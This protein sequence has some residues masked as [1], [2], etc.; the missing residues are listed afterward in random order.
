[1]AD[2][3]LAG[4]L[5]DRRFDFA[6]ELTEPS[7][8]EC[9]GGFK[10]TYDEGLEKLEARARLA[11]AALWAYVAVSAATA[12]GEL[13][14]AAGFLNIEVDMG[15]LAVAVGLTYLAYTAVMLLSVVLVA[16]WIHRAH[17]NLVEGGVDGL[18]FTPGWAVGWYFIPFANLVK[19]FQAMRELWTAS[20]GEHDPFGGQAPS[21]VKAWWA[22]WIV[23]NIL[24]TVS[25]RILLAS[26]GGPSSVTVGNAFGAAGTIGLLI[27]ALLLRKI[28]AD[29]TRAQRGGLTAAGVFA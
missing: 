25:T 20:H 16:M 8:G 23:G 2:R 17:A 18:E 26:E 27:A 28:I 5:G 29:T 14:E 15:A 9:L 7:P 3:S 12:G 24:G 4:E 19:P 21:E 10:M 1:M 11:T 13:L 6:V 22:A